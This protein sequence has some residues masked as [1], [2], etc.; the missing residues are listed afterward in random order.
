MNTLAQKTN[1]VQHI[2]SQNNAMQFKCRMEHEIKMF[3][4]VNYEFSVT[5][6]LSSCINH[7]CGI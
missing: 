2:C 3:L 6:S 1:I 4:D 7:N 5:T